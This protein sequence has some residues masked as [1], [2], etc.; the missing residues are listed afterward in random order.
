MPG[1]YALI[2]SQ[3]IL[4]KS[5]ARQ[6]R[7]S[8]QTTRARAPQLAVHNLE[9]MALE[10]MAQR[11]TVAVITFA[12]AVGARLLGRKHASWAAARSTAGAE[13]SGREGLRSSPRS[14]ESSSSW[15]PLACWPARSS[16]RV[17]CCLLPPSHARW[18]L[19]LC[20]LFATT[21]KHACDHKELQ[22]HCSSACSTQH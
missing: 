15:V 11:R 6:M 8:Q 5:A 10:S 4:N 21:C 9:S 18:L 12:R 3:Y 19:A 13:P 20:R 2:T 7:G 14:P 17:T 1:A 22:V 16:C